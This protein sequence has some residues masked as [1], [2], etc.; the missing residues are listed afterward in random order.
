[1]KTAAWFGSSSRGL[2]VAA[3]VAISFLAYSTLAQAQGT[4]G[5]DAVY[6]AGGTVVGSSAFIDASMFLP[7]NGTRL[8]LCD[9][10]FHILTASTYPASGAVID[11][12]GVSGAS[13]LTCTHGTPW[14]EGSTTVNVP[15]TI[16]LPAG[17]IQ[18]QATWILPSNTRL[19]GEGEGVTCT[20]GPCSPF[21]P[22]TTIQVNGFTG[23]MIQFGSSSVCSTSGGIC[24]GIS[25]E[26]LTLDGQAT[27]IDGILNQYSGNNTYVDHVTLYQILRTGLL[28]SGSSAANSGPYTNIVFDTGG[29]SGNSSTVCAWI[30]GTGGTK[31]IHGLRCK[32]ETNDAP[33]AVLLDDSNNSIQDVTIVGFYASAS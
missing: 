28:I 21:T 11:A 3:V 23:P 25:V 32:S 1:M 5:Q 29:Y 22:G 19:I 16:L 30:N 2:V 33:A 4:Q 9:A 8:D 6:N 27:A 26:R 10:I 31:G 24:S 14:T 13:N 17:T 12:R 7:P 15:S 20:S 18:I